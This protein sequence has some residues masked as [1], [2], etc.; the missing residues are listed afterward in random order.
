MTDFRAL[1][2]ALTQNQVEFILVGGAAATAHGS[3]RLTL[4]L[5]IVYR[6]TAEN[7]RRLANALAPL[8]PYLRDTPPGLPF[9]LHEKTLRSGLNFMLTTSVG[10]LDLFGEI[11]G[12]GGYDDLKPQTNSLDLFGMRC[13]VLTLR[14]LIEVKRAAGRPKDLEVIAELEAIEEERETGG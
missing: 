8:D 6:R 2:S 10:A 5:D 3:T 9:V 13:L 11:T 7:I 1:L 4:D 14:R 12:G